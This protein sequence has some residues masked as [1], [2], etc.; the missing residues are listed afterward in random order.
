MSI[1]KVMILKTDTIC[2]SVLRYLLGMSFIFFFI[3][4]R[5]VL[6]IYFQQSIFDGFIFPLIIYKYILFLND[7]YTYRR[8]NV[9]RLRQIE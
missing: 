3:S 7:V 4:E 2:V 6:R 5:N 1:N 8:N 9:I